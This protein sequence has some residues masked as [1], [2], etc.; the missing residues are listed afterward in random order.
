MNKY[1]LKATGKF[2][3]FAVF[4]FSVGYLVTVILNYL[5]PTFVQLASVFLTTVFVYLAY[6]FITIQADI[7]RRLDEANKNK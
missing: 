7:F 6:I 2:V 5:N 3:L 4:T 1:V